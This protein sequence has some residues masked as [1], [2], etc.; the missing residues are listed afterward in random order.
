MVLQ[1][2]KGEERPIMY[3]SKKLTPS[4]R[5]YS[6]IESDVLAVKWAI[7]ALRYYL[8]ETQFVLIMSL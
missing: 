8:L 3:L 4:E 5:K 7:S 1:K 2:E 6:T